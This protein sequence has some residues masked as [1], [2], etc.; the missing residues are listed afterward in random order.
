[1]R[2]KNLSWMIH[3]VGIIQLG[4]HQVRRALQRT[5]SCLQLSISLEEQL[6]R[7]LDLA[8]GTGPICMRN[9][10]CGLAEDV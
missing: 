9:R 5:R 10:G 3:T 8:V 4:A 6:Q 7:N 1:M 2:S